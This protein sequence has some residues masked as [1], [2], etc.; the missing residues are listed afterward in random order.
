M[1]PS[2]RPYSGRE[3]RRRYAIIAAAYFL[4]CLS[5]LL[6]AS[7]ARAA[8]MQAAP[9]SGTAYIAS[10]AG[11]ANTAASHAIVIEAGAQRAVRILKVCAT[12]PGIQTTAGYRVLLL[13]RTTGAGD[14]GVITAEAA[15]A[16]AASLAK[17]DAGSAFSGIVR[18]KPTTL[19]T[20][21]ATLAALP[22][23]VP[24]AGAAFVP[25]CLDFTSGYDRPP[26][27][28]AGVAHGIALRDPG[29]DGGASF[30]AYVVFAEE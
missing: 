17:G 20:Q 29:A 18:A 22:I 13:E 23:W 11:Q 15:N 12:H 24:T 5:L 26:R 25:T 10:V 28:P 1:H 14:A 2:Y 6:F 19:G 8:Q 3:E 4:F 16:T 9:P 30:A 21:G 7:S 27:I